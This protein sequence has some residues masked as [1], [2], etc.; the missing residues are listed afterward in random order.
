MIMPLFHKP[1]LISALFLISICLLIFNKNLRKKTLNQKLQKYNISPIAILSFILLSIIITD[2]TGRVIKKLELRD[3]P[4]VDKEISQVNCPVC[5]IDKDNKNLYS[6]NGKSAQKSFP[7]NHAANSFALALIISFFFPK[8]KK[9][10]YLLAFIISF[11]RV[12][13]GVHYP[14]DILYGMCLGILA[15]Y[16]VKLF[17]KIYIRNKKLI[18]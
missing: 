1:N 13:I 12:Y 9:A 15:G 18:G 10:M 2:Q 16:F 3:R 17:F 11:S 6:T 8:I 14:F 5:K 7:S 4:W